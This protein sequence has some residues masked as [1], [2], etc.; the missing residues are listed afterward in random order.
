M[1]SLLHKLGSELKSQ[2][3]KKR[4]SFTLKLNKLLIRLKV[5]QSLLNFAL[6]L[7]ENKTFF[8]PKF[9]YMHLRY[10]ISTSNTSALRI[11]SSKPCR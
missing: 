7:Y 4:I 5:T 8:A 11:Q 6:L 1:F 3:K 10:V 2:K 9:V